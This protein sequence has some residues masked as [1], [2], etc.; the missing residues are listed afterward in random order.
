M[1]NGSFCGSVISH[2]NVK[3]S[4]DCQKGGEGTPPGA[5]GTSQPSSA[6]LHT[7]NLKGVGKYGKIKENGYCGPYRLK[8]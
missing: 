1:E 8:T 4:D 7:D 3:K 6:D 5:G 2:K